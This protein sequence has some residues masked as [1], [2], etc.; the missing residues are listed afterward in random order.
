MLTRRHVIGGLAATPLVSG[1]PAA[2]SPCR[3][4][5]SV[6]VVLAS[7]REGGGDIGQAGGPPG[8]GAQERGMLAGAGPQ[9]VREPRCGTRRH[10]QD[11]LSLF[12]GLDV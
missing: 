12:N 5:E 4:R 6:L 2:A 1:L 10:R 8:I 9:S 3:R 11:C 7:K